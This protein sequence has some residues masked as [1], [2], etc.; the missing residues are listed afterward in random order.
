MVDFEISDRQKTSARNLNFLL[1]VYH[2]D[3]KAQ[4]N[5]PEKSPIDEVQRLFARAVFSGSES[6]EDF[7]YK[8]SP[9]KRFKE[10]DGCCKGN[11]G[12]GGAG[13]VLRSVDDDFVYSCPLPYRFRVNGKSETRSLSS[14]VK[15]QGKLPKDQFVSFEIEHIHREY[16]S[17]ADALAN[18]GLHL[19]G[20]SLQ[21][22]IK[23]VKL[24]ENYVKR[25][26]RQAGFDVLFGVK[27]NS[28]M[29]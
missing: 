6:E 22:T 26:S 16:N 18:K 23:M 24:K 20:E 7:C 28:F 21:D 3:F 27:S 14:Y 1:H 17:E 12:K 10:F 25:Y 29:L 15:R 13:A 4:A 9:P 5:G 19:R 8:A 11:P 2:V